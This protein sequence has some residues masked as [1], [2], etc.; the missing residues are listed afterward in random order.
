[1]RLLENPNYNFVG[2]RKYAYIFSGSLVLISILAV[3]FKGPQ[4]G[5]EFKGGKSYVVQ[6]EEPV[7]VT[8]IRD[9]LE[10]P[11]RGSPQVKTYGSDREILIQTD[12]AGGIGEVQG[13]IMTNLRELYPGIEMEV[14]KSSI[15]GPRFADDLR[16][17]AINAIIFACIVIFIYILIRFK[18]WPFS[19]G[20]VA[21]LAHDVLIVLGIFV[22][23]AG[24]AP[25]SMEI[26]QTIIAAFLTI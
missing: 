16:N 17:A 2:S 10:G 24:I 23:F 13:L 19:V 18:S 21:A 25:F 12:Y 22:I 4:Y 1:M 20:A 5:I 11:L 26:D 15:V 3:I 9:A 14:V 8:A 7:S 6:F